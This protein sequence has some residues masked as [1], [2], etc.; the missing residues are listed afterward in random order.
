M[1]L[2][3]LAF[4]VLLGLAFF[5]GTCRAQTSVEYV[6]IDARAPVHPFPHFWE[7]MFGS[8]RAIL[9]LRESY[10][11]DLREVKKV[12]EFGYVRFH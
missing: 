6:V 1:K 4:G 2:S 8:G 12:T 9:S 5:A 10:R 11:S 3:R 7:Q